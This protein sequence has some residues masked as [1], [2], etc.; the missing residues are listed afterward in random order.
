M[1]NSKGFITRSNT[2]LKE[3]VLLIGNQLSMDVAADI[4]NSP[5]FGI[6]TDEVTDISNMSQLVTFVKYFDARSG[7]ASTKFVGIT[8]ILAD[9]SAPDAATIHDC[10]VQQI[11][12]LNLDMKDAAAFSSDG[13]SVMLGK[14]N[15]VVARL[16]KN[17]GCEKMLNIHC[18][19]HRLALACSDTGDEIKFI[20]EFELTLLQLWKYFKNSSKRLK[21]Y[22]KTTLQMRDFDN[23]SN[24]K[25]R[26]VYSEKNK[27][28]R[29]NTDLPECFS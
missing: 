20:E 19:C 1:T 17:P 26:K 13:P 3:L 4:R 21:V 8:D 16:K 18:I 10:L 9:S 28:K 25:K 2:V 24:E 22:I 27:K 5:L 11:Q 14:E 6:L 29:S 12:D 15:G 7:E 23:F